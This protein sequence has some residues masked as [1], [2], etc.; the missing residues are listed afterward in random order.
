MG[1]HCVHNPESSKS[2][3]HWKE[4]SAKTSTTK[5][6]ITLSTAQNT[7]NIIPVEFLKKKLSPPHRSTIIAETEKLPRKKR[8]A[9]T[10]EEPTTRTDRITLP[11]IGPGKW[12]RVPRWSCRRMRRPTGRR[13]G[14]ASWA[15]PP[16]GSSPARRPRP[17]SSAH[18]NYVKPATNKNKR[19]RHPHSDAP[20]GGCEGWVC[21]ET[22]KRMK[23]E[24]GRVTWGGVR[25]G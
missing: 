18:P 13:W 4:P 1:K 12:R 10:R 22:A 16:P 5:H 15:A 23:V 14:P 11:V 2:W 8:Q 6:T 3:I 7:Q 25:G 21:Y 20:A 17:R 19:A 24:V 9:A